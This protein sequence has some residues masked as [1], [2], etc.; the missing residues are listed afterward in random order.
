MIQIYLAIIIAVLSAIISGVV[1]FLI[2]LI[3]NKEMITK[4]KFLEEENNK[5][6]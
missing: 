2:M 4:L 1:V 6:S 5:R 3:N